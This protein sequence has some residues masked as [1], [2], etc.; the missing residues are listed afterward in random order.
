M[1]PV[2]KHLPNALG[3]VRLA[4]VP[5][6]VWL[7]LDARWEAAFWVF[8][9]GGLSDALDGYVA[10]R[11][12]LVS[13]FGE[14]LDPVADKAL[15]NG[16]YLSLA[17]AGLVPW[18]LAVLV[19]GRDLI[20]LGVAVA[21]RLLKPAIPLLPLALGKAN[22]FFQVGFAALVLAIAAYGWAIPVVRDVTM[23]ATAL[24]TLLSGLLYGASWYRHYRAARQE[25][26]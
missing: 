24:L 13:R 11:F 7:V 15:M 8:L 2:V 20:I 12:D 21:T 1:T 10:R 22:T 9:L 16:A 6:L 3:L 23:A 4:A 19:A 17:A 26:A 25:R 14:I 18:W 5:V